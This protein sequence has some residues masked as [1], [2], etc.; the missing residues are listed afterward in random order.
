MSKRLLRQ[1]DIDYIKNHF[2]LYDCDS[3]IEKTIIKALNHTLEHL[4]KQEI[5]GSKKWSDKGTV[6]KSGNSKRYDLQERQ[7]IATEKFVEHFTDTITI[8]ADILRK[9][10]L[11]TEGDEI[12]FTHKATGEEFI[13]TVNKTE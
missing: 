10:S 1:H 8:D 13:A 7:T 3:S 12:T 9:T 6:V 5:T 11:I 4:D 2:R